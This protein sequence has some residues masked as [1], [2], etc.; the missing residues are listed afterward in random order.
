MN[1]TAPQY[2]P[3]VALHSGTIISVC[4]TDSKCSVF[5]D[6]VAYLRCKD[7]CNVIQVFFR[8]MFRYHWLPMEKLV[9]LPVARVAADGA[10]IAVWVTN[11]K[12]FAQ[13]VV[14]TLFPAWGVKP[15]AEWHW[16]KV[17]CMK[18]YGHRQVYTTDLLLPPLPPP[19]RTHLLR[20][21]YFR[22]K[23]RSC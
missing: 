13:F 1:Q 10:L 7:C 22:G 15:I 8:F 14:D 17:L 21:M 23:P 4:E 5:P 12:K 18:S 20:P 6:M 16:I 11:K 9:E 3:K 19:T 2:A